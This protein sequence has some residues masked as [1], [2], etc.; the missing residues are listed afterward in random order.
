MSL[1]SKQSNA[2]GVLRCTL[3]SM[4]WQTERHYAWAGTVDE[5]ATNR[6]SVVVD[7]STRAT[8]TCKRDGEIE[9]DFAETRKLRSTMQTA[10]DSVN[11][12]G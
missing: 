1:T 12:A 6:V 3:A 8:F 4:G 5:R 7:G 9:L 2:I 11:R 10:A